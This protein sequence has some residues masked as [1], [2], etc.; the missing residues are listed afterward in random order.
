MPSPLR[1]LTLQEAREEIHRRCAASPDRTAT[2]GLETE[3]LIAA[4][5]DR[6]P[7]PLSRI[8][9]AVTDAGPLP[10]DSRITYEPGGQLELSGT[11]ATSAP[12]AIDAIASDL[13]AVDTG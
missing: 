6:T 8:E 10:C 3:W 12:A 1:A 7:V 11:P 5:D 2:V 13:R 9:R 4:G